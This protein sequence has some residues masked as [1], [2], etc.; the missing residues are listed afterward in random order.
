M[1][2]SINEF[3]SVLRGLNIKRK[4]K[5]IQNHHTY[6][7]SYKDFNGKNHEDIISAMK[8]FHTVINKWA[9]IAQHITTFPDG[10]IALCA[11][12]GRGFEHDPAG[13]YG[14]NAGAICIEH[15]GNFDK[16][17]DNMNDVHKETILKMNKI[18]S[19]VFNLPL[20]TSHYVFHHWYDL[21]T[22][23]RINGAG[24]T[25]SCPGT[26]FICGN[27]ESDARVFLNLVATAINV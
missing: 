7:P 18:L 25:K 1:I 6:K 8:Y 22:G 2:I 15:V 21:T 11:P 4:I 23:K 10:K 9:D 17:N 26:N 20:D 19:D 27:T 13:I 12:H 24:D 3:D 16:G 5:L 14:A